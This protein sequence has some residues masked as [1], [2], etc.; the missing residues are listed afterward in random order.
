MPA[1]VRLVLGSLG[2]PPPPTRAS[3]L[4]CACLRSHRLRRGTS[5][6]LPS[7]AWAPRVPPPDLVVYSNLVSFLRGRHL[8]SLQQAEL[9]KG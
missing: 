2:R 9:N 6:V 4:C 7:V 5:F 3:T 1:K 8:P